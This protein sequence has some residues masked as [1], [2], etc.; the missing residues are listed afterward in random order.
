MRVAVT[1]ASGF[2]GGHLVAAL[3]DAGHEVRCLV[4]ARAAAARLEARGVTTVPAGLEDAAALARLAE[5]TELLF[6]VAGLVAARSEAAFLAVNR[7]GTARV[8]RAGLEAG[9]RRVVLVSSLAVTGPSVP[10]RPL[11]ES[12][13]PRPVTPYGRSKRAAEEALVAS[14]AAWTILRPPAVYGPGDRQFLRLFRAARLGL[15][16]LLGDGTQELSL[17]HAADLA[18]AL[19]AAGTSASAE[20]RLYHAAHPRI[21]TQRELV[22]AIGRSVG[23]KVRCVALPAVAVRLLLAVSGLAARLGGGA[24]LLAPDKAP[25][26]LAPAWTCSSEALRRDTGWQARIDLQQGL[27]ATAEAYRREGWL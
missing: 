20:G 10:G 1:G 15:L 21:V 26:L 17:V 11:E 6:H 27:D 24:S 4:R 23:R 12:A 5:G 9:V 2:V 3:L 18:E 16:P 8:A 25:E 7:D 22:H 19:L 14:G 13:A